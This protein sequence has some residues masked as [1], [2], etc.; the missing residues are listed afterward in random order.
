MTVASRQPGASG[1]DGDAI[2]P[3]AELAR[4]AAELRPADLPGRVLERTVD[5]LIDAVA[6]ALAADR[7]EEI[8]AIDR[9]APVLGGPGR[10][11]VIGRAERR[12]PAAAALVNGYRI[13]AL[14]AC[15][16]YTPAHFHVTPE[17][18]PPALAVAEANA[19]DGATL[20]VALAAGL[21]VATR[22]AAGLRYEAFRARGWH[23]PGVAGPLGGAAAAGRVAGLDA[24]RMGHALGLAAS[25]SAGTWAA[26]G[27]AAV[28]FHQ[29]RAA[30][31]GLLAARLAERGFEA[32]EEVLT[33]PDGGLLGTYSDGGTPAALTDGLGERWELERISLRPW[34]GATPLQPMITG[35][36]G[37]VRDGGLEVPSARRVRIA[38]APA[39]HAQHARFRRPSGTFEAMLS[40]DYAAAVILRFGRLGV[41]E[42]LPQVYESPETAA[43]IAGQVEVVADPAL[44][45]LQCRITLDPDTPAE[46]VRSVDRPRG[47]P[48][49]PASRAMILDK[50]A[51][52]AEGVLDRGSL[53]RV[54]D[55]LQDVARAVDASEVLALLRPPL[56]RSGDDR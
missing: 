40:L 18:V 20:V 30:L 1:P 15:D 29:A 54:A 46:V 35:L 41:A 47:H 21:E 49:H 26:W 51:A 19:A 14:T 23:T 27:T 42:F 44:S 34:P 16:V 6:C 17:V 38:V 24:R 13:T 56:G 33:H 25:Q 50:L 5:L 4:F 12:S 3:T 53:E 10:S 22:V 52:C 8:D 48:D 45:P 2:R 11:T 43:V 36:L 31:S 28:K 32:G 7:A 37:L 39:V 55:G 9:L